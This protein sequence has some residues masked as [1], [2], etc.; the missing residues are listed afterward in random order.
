MYSSTEKVLSPPQPSHS[1]PDGPLGILADVSPFVDGGVFPDGDELVLKRSEQ[2]LPRY[3]VHFKRIPK[4]R[5]DEDIPLEMRNVPLIILWVDPNTK[6][7]HPLSQ[8]PNVRIG[9]GRSNFCFRP[10]HI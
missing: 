7:R 10:H 6:V 2:C 8:K 5:R 9:L 3:L 4:R 1:P